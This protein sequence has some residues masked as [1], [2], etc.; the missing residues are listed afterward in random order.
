MNMTISNEIHRVIRAHRVQTG[1][2]PERLIMNDMTYNRL[3]AELTPLMSFPDLPGP[4]P[5]YFEGVA[6]EPFQDPEPTVELKIMAIG[7]AKY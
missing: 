3:I 7:G 6:I 1:E 2:Y 4:G 5:D